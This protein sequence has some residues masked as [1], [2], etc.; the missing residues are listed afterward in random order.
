MPPSD[1]SSWSFN[2]PVLLKKNRRTSSVLV[3]TLAGGT[4]FGTAWAFLAPLPQTV[5]V[6]G[7][8][9]PASGV[10][11]IEASVPGVV[12]DVAVVEGQRVARGDLLLRFDARDAETRLNSAQ[13]NRDR[14]Q[15]QVTINRVVLGEQPESSLSA[16]QKALLKSQ[17]QDNDGNL[18]AESAAIRRSKVSI[19]GLR[20]SLSTAE[21]VADRYQALQREGASSELQVVA[22]L[23]KVTEFRTSL[24]A[25]EEELIRL[26]SRRDADQGGREARLR[27]EIEANL[28]RIASL[29]TEI[30][31]AEVL[32]SR[33]SVQAPI[34]GL[35][36]DLNVSRGDVVTGGKGVKPMLQI[37]PEDDLQAKIYIPN[38]AIGFI[39]KGQR[40]D[41]SL[42]A[43]NASDYG[44]LPATVQRIGSDALTPKEQQRELGQ[45]AKGLYFPA[46]LKLDS[47]ALMVGQRSVPL[48]PGM[49]LTADLHLR[50]RRFISA[51]T[52]MFDDK[53]RSLQ[54]LP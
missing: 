1:N 41:I 8:L 39:R 47:Q 52:D 51:I 44:Y 28:N 49:S 19:A 3:W 13:R 29:D 45:D 30:R 34:S 50:T 20:Q 36:F 42:A 6:Q 18:Q 32:L 11:A 21:M 46:T 48:Q 26:Q 7:K 24:D 43:F 14:L 40:A 31:K 25:E 12:D 27:K 10:Q 23:A 54:R 33:I 17:R 16:N 4:A 53:Q 35:V 22:A 38:E 15:N 2:Q 37:I 9:Q 5:A